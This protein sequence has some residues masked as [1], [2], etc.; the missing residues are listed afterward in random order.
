[1]EEASPVFQQLAIILYVNEATVRC[2]GLLPNIVYDITLIKKLDVRLDGLF[3]VFGY[4][5][6]A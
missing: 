6:F 4:F 3:D 1:M 2:R 5:R